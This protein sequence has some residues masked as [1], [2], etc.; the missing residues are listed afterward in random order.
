MRRST[1]RWEIRP[2]FVIYVKKNRYENILKIV[3]DYFGGIGTIYYQGMNV[4]YRVNSVKDLFNIIIPHFVNYPLLSTKVS[5]FTLWSKAIYLMYNGQHKEDSGR[6]EIYS[7]HAAINQGPS[8][9]FKAYFPNW[10][11]AK[12]PSYSLNIS[13]EELSNWWV[14]GYFSMYCHFKIDLDPHGIK[15]SY[16]YRVV[17]SFNFSR[18][19]T[20]LSL[21]TLLAS[22]FGVT[23]NQRSDNLRVDVNIYG[24]HKNMD[25]VDL[26]ESYPLMSCKQEEFEIW[27]TAI[28]YAI[29]LRRRSSKISLSVYIKHFFDLSEK[30]DRVR[31]IND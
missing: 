6:H 3:K 25:I 5:T 29:K 20:E 18:S 12:L 21:L 8:K 4:A 24:L 10:Q 17:P 28:K 30:L 31:K 26:F 19:I 16:Y 9:S 11:P 13:P 15:N 7:I 23:I 14:S 22:Y 27:A 1:G 2:E